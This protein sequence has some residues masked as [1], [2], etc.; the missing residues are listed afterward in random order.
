MGL[1]TRTFLCPRCGNRAWSSPQWHY[2]AACEQ[3][4]DRAGRTVSDADVGDDHFWKN[5]N[6]QDP[7]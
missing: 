4:F 6:E 3:H 7:E 2:C 1:N 5:N